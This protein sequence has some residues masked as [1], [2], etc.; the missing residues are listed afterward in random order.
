[1][2]WLCTPRRSSFPWQ[3]MM[4]RW[5]TV[6]AMAE[7]RH[8][9]AFHT[10]GS[11]MACS[12]LRRYSGLPHSVPPAPLCPTCRQSQVDHLHS[13]L[14][15]LVRKEPQLLPDFLPEVL[16][17]QVGPRC[18]WLPACLLGGAHKAVVP[19]VRQAG[20]LLCATWR[21]CPAQ[22]V[23]NRSRPHPAS[24]MCVLF[25]SRCAQ[26]EHSP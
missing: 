21:I 3:C 1:M 7:A 8:A 19:A 16:E 26:R 4:Q 23:V 11:S 24:Q 17:L 20:G 22:L 14:E 10:V 6:A 12:R 5:I 18:C 25:L 15:L 13:L 2:P 9:T